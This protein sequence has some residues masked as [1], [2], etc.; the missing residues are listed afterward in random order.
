METNCI[1]KLHTQELPQNFTCMQNHRVVLVI[2]LNIVVLIVDLEDG[3]Q[4]QKN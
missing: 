4:K 2:L 1:M 3:Q